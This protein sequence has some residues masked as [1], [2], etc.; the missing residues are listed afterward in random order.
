MAGEIC[1]VRAAWESE[2]AEFT[3]PLLVSDLYYSQWKTVPEKALTISGAD[4]FSRRGGT[5][6]L[7]AIFM[8]QLSSIGGIGTNC[9]AR[10]HVRAPKAYIQSTIEALYGAPL[11]CH[12]CKPPTADN[13]RGAKQKKRL[14]TANE[15]TFQVWPGFLFFR[16]NQDLASK[17]EHA[18]G[19]HAVLRERVLRQMTP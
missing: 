1:P 4:R 18:L 15:K 10:R 11:F 8:N 2:R 19:E 6:R 12:V 5:C 3:P 7:H 14:L 13:D 17:R 16:V 9:Q